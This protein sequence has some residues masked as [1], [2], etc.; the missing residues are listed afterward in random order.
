MAIPGIPD[1]DTS[2]EV[3]A[4][5]GYHTG[6]HSHNISLEDMY[7]GTYQMLYS[8]DNDSNIFKWNVGGP[9]PEDKTGQLAAQGFVLPGRTISSDPNDNIHVT[10]A[11]LGLED[12]DLDA[13]ESYEH[14]AFPGTPT[15]WEDRVGVYFSVEKSS[16]MLVDDGDVYEH[17][18]GLYLDDSIFGPVVGFDPDN[19]QMDALIVYDIFADKKTFGG[20]NDL[21]N[22]DAIFFS[23]A[24][25]TC[26]P[27]GDNI[28]WYSAAFGGVGGLYADP[29]L[30]KNVD[31][32]DVPE[33]ATMLLLGS[34]LLGLAG[35]SRKKFNKS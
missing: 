15:D 21:L 8:V 33:P 31:A 29:G 32:L 26:D 16:S 24:P 22:S 30:N 2:A 1:R 6:D 19:E 18:I 35:F 7:F 14:D 3:D 4:L 13:L 28:Y 11:D 9:P 34:G 12:Y 5:S 25:G 20:G 23:L 17:F 27:I 10:A